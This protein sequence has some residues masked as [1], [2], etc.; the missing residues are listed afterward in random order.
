MTVG[1]YQNG[2]LVYCGYYCQYHET[3][4]AYGYLKDMKRFEYM[5]C[6]VRG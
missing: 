4:S 1:C 3:C 6:L 5:G 2:E